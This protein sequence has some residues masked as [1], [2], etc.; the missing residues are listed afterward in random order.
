MQ[1]TNN[2][3]YT[4]KAGVS[5]LDDTNTL[6]RTLNNTAS[7]FCGRL[8]CDWL[9]EVRQ[10]QRVWTS[11]DRQQNLVQCPNRACRYDLQPHTHKLS[12]KLPKVSAHIADTA[13]YHSISADQGASYVPTYAPTQ[14]KVHTWVMPF[15]EHER[16]ECM[17]P[18][19][20]QRPKYAQFEGCSSFWEKK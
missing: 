2:I 19:S 1:L 10:V 3:S 20:D 8:V 13:F 7:C 4:I 11:R 17:F 5:V 15:Q 14:L 16:S 18:I 12:V 6:Y 9:I